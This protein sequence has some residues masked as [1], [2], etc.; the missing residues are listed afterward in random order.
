[1]PPGAVLRF[2]EMFDHGVL[3]PTLQ[4]VELLLPGPESLRSILG[5]KNHNLSSSGREKDAW[6]P[7]FS[8]VFYVTSFLQSC[9]EDSSYSFYHY[10]HIAYDWPKPTFL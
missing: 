1:M 3:R 4:I 7:P 5:H 8:Q 2:F 6:T 9:R 10:T